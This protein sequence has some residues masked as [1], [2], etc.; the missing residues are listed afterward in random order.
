MN[1]RRIYVIAEAGVNHNGDMDLAMKLIDAAVQAGAD[2]IKFQTFKTKNLV[3]VDAPKARYQNESAENRESQFAMLKRLELTE[4]AHFQLM[5]YCAEKGID[6]LSTPFDL[7]SLSFLVDRLHLSCLKIS[8]GDITNG[9]LLLAAAKRGHK[10]ILSTGISTL[11]EIERALSVLAFGY[12]GDK[13]E[14]SIENFER[15]YC[16]SEGQASLMEKVV[17]LHCTTEYPAPFADVNLRAMDT[18]RNAF[19][20]AVGYSDHTCGIAIPIAA[21]ARGAQ[22]IEKHFTMDRTLPGPDHKASLEPQELMQMIQA[23]RQVEDGLGTALK[24]PVPSEI[25]NRHIARKSL[26]ASRPIQKG[27]SFS[28]DNISSKRPGNGLSPMFYWNV[29]GKKAKRGYETDESLS[30]EEV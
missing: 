30:A 13:Q 12:I 2:A 16:S 26:V 1:Y 25:E 29:I 22:V 17:L 20:L 8:S 21:A 7:P 14:T 5:Q 11:S 28:C 23:V 18:L 24:R 4:A 9:P 3:C 27:E 15:A 10:I 6:F 19:G